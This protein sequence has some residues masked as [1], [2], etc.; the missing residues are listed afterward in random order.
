MME[1]CHFI[2]IGGIGMSGLAKIV[3]ARNIKVSGS[4]LSMNAL[5]QDLQ[6][7]GADVHQNHSAKWIEPGTTVVFS[8]DI[9]K[10]NPEFQ[11]ALE[12]NCPML[13]R[14]DLLH[15][16]MKDYR[17]LAVSGTHGKTTTSA[18]LLSVMLEAKTDPSFAIG[19]ILPQ[20]G[21]N[22]GHGKGSYFVAEADE[23]DGTFLK[24]TPHGAIVT[25]IDLD[26]MNH[27]GTEEQLVHSFSQ[28]LNK[29][30]DPRLLLW[31]GDDHRLSRLNPKG[32]SYGFGQECDL[33]ITAFVQR[34]WN[35][36]F[37]LTYCGKTYQNIELAL[38][39]RHNVLNGAAVFGL[40]LNLGIDESAIRSAFSK[41][42]G[43]LRRSEKKGECH[44]IQF[45]DDYGHHPT[46]IAATLGSI[47]NA[48]GEKRLVAVYQPHRF[49]RTKECLGSFKGTF[50]K[51][52]IVIITDI[53]GA[54]EPNP[55]HLHAKDVVK[56]VQ[57]HTKQQVI[58]IPKEELIE[59][60]AAMLRPH[61]VMI[62]FGAGDIT[63]FSNKMIDNLEKN[64]PKKWVV[65]VV[66]GGKSTEHEIS[67]RSAKNVLSSLRK[68]FY[69]VR[70]FGISKEGYWICGPDTMERCE[71][72]EW[73]NANT[74]IDA[75][76]WKEMMA[77]DL[78][79]PVLHGPFGEDGTIQGFFEMIDK[80]YVGCD[81]R[82]AAICMDKVMTK[83]LMQ[84][85]NI[86]IVP[87]IHF[88]RYEWLK[89]KQ[90]ILNKA[91]AEL[92]FP[93]F[94]KP[95]HL[96]STVG[97]V[98]AEREDLEKAIDESV[99]YDTDVLVEN[100]LN[101]REIEFSVWG[102]DEVRT[103]PPGEIHSAGKVY[104]YDSKYGPQSMQSTPTT[105]LS[106]DLIKK[107][108]EIAVNAYKA[109]GCCGM[110]RVDTFLDEN[111]CF[112]LNEINPIPGFTNISLFPAICVANGMPQEDLA[113]LLIIL[114]L[115]RKRSQRQ[116]SIVEKPCCH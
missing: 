87:Y 72:G 93:V 12:L 39:G 27:F 111:N 109:A 82:G 42:K 55:F 50:E 38:G 105:D 52:D 22:A 49:T 77:C 24:Y 5:V 4:D 10:D 57:M 58:F 66:Y 104:T 13:H 85:H 100:G 43:V 33:N 106:E 37:D 14:S 83:K 3:M 30:D 97:V 19:G 64:P 71:K 116:M 76:V 17:T 6:K 35:T 28:F 69:D 47:R 94:V 86:P 90:E 99:Y 89:S 53:Y 103:F 41:F 29:I 102:N 115:Q 8:S 7:K 46:E 40:C 70:H 63:H 67:L 107:G 11:A 88:S 114:G 78:F 80:A 23:S 73:L 91:Y 18:L 44:G 48:I 79:F 20:I 98:K 81:H 45:L 2:G 113:D 95:L 31:C 56:D 54:G 112:W 51:A 65:G 60:T 26:H 62:T 61:D 16:L 74:P 68:D 101:I 15:L 21:T 34:G 9:K 59:K 75:E 110:A 108:M 1:K 96:G 36:Y 84:V 32:T 92:S 25:N